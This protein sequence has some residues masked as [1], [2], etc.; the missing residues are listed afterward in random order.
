M[1]PMLNMVFTM[2]VMVAVHMVMIMTLVMVP[3]NTNNPPLR[4]TLISGTLQ[5]LFSCARTCSV[6]KR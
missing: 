2:V 3:T 5:R 6:Q 1:P 4:S